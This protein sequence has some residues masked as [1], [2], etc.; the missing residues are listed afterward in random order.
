[1][2]ERSPIKKPSKSK[3]D[4]LAENEDLRARLEESEDTL[5][6]IRKG[7]VDAFM[8]STPKGEQGFTIKG[9]DYTYRM[10]IEKM[11]E[12]AVTLA[13]D[14]TILY[15]NRRF[16]EM[17]GKPLKAVV[18]AP[19]QSLVNVESESALERILKSSRDGGGQEE[20]LL[21][22][23]PGK[24]RPVMVS[25]SFLSMDEG[26]VL[27]LIVTDLAEKKR[28]EKIVSAERLSRSIL[29]Q[30]GEIIIVCDENARMIR[31]SDAARELMGNFGLPCLF[32]RVFPLEI[33]PSAPD[34]KMFDLHEVLKG[35]SR[36]NL[37]VSLKR[38]SKVS[39]FLLSARPLKGGMGEIIGCVV[40]LTDIS[41]RKKREGDRKRF[42]RAAQQNN[43]RLTEIL[44]SISDA[45]VA[46]DRDWCF[47]YI[48]ARAAG[49]LGRES[50]GLIGRN[51]WKEFPRLIGTPLEAN[52]RKAL[53][54]NQTVHF[55]IQSRDTGKWYMV[56]AYPSAE[57]LSIY[58]LE[59][60]RQ[61]QMEEALR[62]YQEQLEVKIQQRTEDILKR[63]KE[64]DCLYTVS[65]LL[66]R[67]Q[68]SWEEILQKTVYAIPPGW[69]FSDSAS[70][71]IIL[72]GR[73]FKGDNF[74]ET[75]WIQRSGIFSR[76]K[77]VGTLE[78]CYVEAKAAGED[79]PFMKEERTL[80]KALA[81]QIGDFL[82]R[83]EVQES[84]RETNELLESVFSSIDLH[85]AYMDKDFNFLRV[86][87]AYAEA[88]GRSPEFF[89]GKNHFDL[90]PNEENLAIFRNV[91]ETG[92]PYFVS[93]KPF[94]YR[95]HPEK[96]VTHWDWSLQPVRDLDGRVIG[97][98][99]SLVNVTARKRTQEALWQTEE[100]LH[101]IVQ[102]LPVGVWV[103]DRNGTIIMSNPAAEQIWGGTKYLPISQYEKYKGW[104][105]ASRIKSEDWALA[106]AVRDGETSRNEVVEI[107]SFDGKRKMVLNSAVP[108]RG[109]DR[110]IIGA[111]AV[112]EDITELRRAEEALRGAE[113]N[114]RLIAESMTEVIFAYDLK[115]QLLFVNPA[116][117]QLTGYTADELRENQEIQWVHPE[118]SDRVR[119]IWGEGFQGTQG[120][121]L[122][123]RILTK[124]GQVKWCQSSWTPLFD[125]SGVRIGTVIV[126]RD[127]TE[128]K[129]TEQER[130]RLVTAIEQTAEG[131][132]ILDGNRTI[133]YLN[134]AFERLHGVP[135]E[136]ILGEKYERIVGTGSNEWEE[137]PG[138][139]ME[140]L[141]WEEGWSRH[142]T[143]RRKDGGMTELELRIFPVKDASGQPIHYVAVER[144]V[145]QEVLTQE[146][147][148]QFQKMEALGT[149][150][151][152]VAHDFNNILMPILI[153]TDLALLDLREGIPAPPHYLDLVRQAA[154][155]GQ[156]LVKQIIAFSRHKEQVRQQIKVTPIVKETLKFL[157]ASLPKDIE[158]RGKIGVETGVIL[159]DPT[160]V[161][162]VLM[163][164]S[165]NAAHAMRDGG[166]VLEV[167]VT[168]EIL[169]EKAG[170][171]P[172]L[173]PGAYLRMSIRDTGH[174]M[175]KEVLEKAFD[176]FFT[177]KPP[178]EGTGMGLAVVHGIVKNHGGGI[179]LESEP[180]KGTAIHVFFP[181]I[182]EKAEREISP[183]GPIPEGKERIL[184]VDDEEIQVRSIRNMLERL[185]Y[186]VVGTTDAREALEMFRSRPRDFDLVITDQ[187]MPGL[188]GDKLALEILNIRPDIPVILCT[189]FS[190]V[191]DEKETKS[192]GISDF[193]MKPITLYDLASRI[194]RV[195]EAHP[196]RLA[197]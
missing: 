131:V 113:R 6:A 134:P 110:E 170:V 90:Y 107:E 167:E 42:E 149:L 18:G 61:K 22:G 133:L 102:T 55:E 147:M 50:P 83:R 89:P 77:R 80:I 159:A 192:L 196:P 114:L 119:K 171:Y 92:E 108:L 66:S 76:G 146:R 106:R 62:S 105:A 125:E 87:R 59:I 70:A 65:N 52:Y 193:V 49:D 177:T 60:T 36:R 184:L 101:K 142:I 99:L 30:A 98:V 9:A 103:A 11:H 71:R 126:D 56:S 46:L 35:E 78:V 4:L 120:S 73:E 45:F 16:A 23:A 91:V 24:S 156:E 160:Q 53:E 187:S 48:N 3:Q 175:E 82:T 163:N 173:K 12:G 150:A 57:G 117:K 21:G 40:I 189:G 33:S 81:D 124:E 186:G 178:G 27:F 19:I 69:H 136:Q 135:R 14:G 58:W 123:F 17:A 174:G 41:E 74:R 68:G 115:G 164:L 28:T 29:E 148:R 44:E 96:G 93:E 176:P 139:L 185:G 97:V 32:S 130:M 100:I 75:P 161:H 31:T 67:E 169:Q 20:I 168:E 165:T 111:I 2:R 7:E 172:G 179:T 145:T 63:L 138:R 37:E 183:G 47:T 118:D 127:I 155:R 132:A 128:R 38:A 182:Q 94:T 39:H 129:I 109:P 180:G 10:L 191:V 190:E 51:I 79:G 112:H 181:R 116:V 5:R 188:R 197:D 121:N 194:R 54:R 122:E 15:S 143:R 144:D 26:E 140:S 8:I 162:Q 64:L 157:K 95:D 104:R 85:V 25:G 137:I 1:M 72:N 158:I 88:D 153:N 86:N 195:L 154:L 43:R 166:G 151:G 34:K 141:R 84:L 152:G 13:A